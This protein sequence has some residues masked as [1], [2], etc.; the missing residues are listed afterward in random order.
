[1]KIA[2]LVEDILYHLVFHL[3]VQLKRL[4]ADESVESLSPL[5]KLKRYSHP[6]HTHLTT[7]NAPDFKDTVPRCVLKKKKTSTDA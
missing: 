5:Y 1:M 4:W 7:V 2:S 6:T 3:H